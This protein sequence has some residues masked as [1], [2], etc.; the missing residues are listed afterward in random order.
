MHTDL[1]PGL[2]ADVSARASAEFRQRLE[3]TQ[4]K[5]S[6]APCASQARVSRSPQSL[7]HPGGA[8]CL[9]LEVE[10]VVGDLTPSASRGST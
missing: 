8:S 1:T 3:L 7:P 9:I 10:Q 2:L 5:A 6:L 4:C